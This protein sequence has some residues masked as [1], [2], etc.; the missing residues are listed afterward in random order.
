MAKPKDTPRQWPTGTGPLGQSGV[1]P[2]TN[3]ERSY[4]ELFVRT[5]RPA[6]LRGDLSSDSPEPKSRSYSES[7]NRAKNSE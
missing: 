7:E 3:A 4:E 6:V 1:S 5:D 2:S